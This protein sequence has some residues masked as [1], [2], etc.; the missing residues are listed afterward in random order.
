MKFYDPRS[1]LDCDLNVNDQV[2][3]VNTQLLKAYCDMHP[4]VRPIIAVVKAWAKSLG[5]NN[6]AGQGGRA[7]T[8]NSYALALMT[9]GFFQVRSPLCCRSRTTLNGFV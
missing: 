9:V 2:G 4:F 1:E 5:L 8:F 6:P 3:V 7:I